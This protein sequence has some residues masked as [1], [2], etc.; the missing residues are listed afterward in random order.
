LF[1]PLAV[2]NL[3]ENYQYVSYLN[4]I[5][6]YNDEVK[7]TQLAP[8]GYEA[9]EVGQFDS[10]NNTGWKNR[11]ARFLQ[12]DNRK[13]VTLS[14]EPFREDAVTFIGRLHT[15]LMHCKQGL[16]P[17]TTMLI[18]L[19]FT[20]SDDFPIW[21][22]AGLV[23]AEYKLVVEQC[24]L[25]VPVAKLNAAID[26]ALTDKMSKDKAGYY[27]REMTCAKHP[28][29]AGT[30]HYESGEIRP[31]GQATLKVFI[32]FVKRRAFEGHQVSIVKD[33]F[34]DIAIDIV[35]F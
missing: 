21:C 14:E 8:Q 4:D 31:P 22:P 15:N 34:S 18:D 28:I 25:Y 9:D 20:K 1:S 3:T 2:Q 5:L 32:A 16:V 26:K 29:N 23:S 12:Y 7:R 27:Y 6:D 13:G 33:K 24:V 11:R 19:E 30:S 17:Y 10:H 35:L